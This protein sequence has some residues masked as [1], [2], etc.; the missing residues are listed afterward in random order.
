MWDEDPR[1]SL[2]VR[3]GP[4]NGASSPC[5]KNSNNLSPVLTADEDDF[6]HNPYIGESKQLCPYLGV[7]LFAYLMGFPDFST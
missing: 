4:V 6:G 3:L 7:P 2:D 5:G 1:V